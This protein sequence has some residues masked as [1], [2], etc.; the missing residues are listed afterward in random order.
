MATKSTQIALTAK[1]TD[2]QIIGNA[3]ANLITGNNDGIVINGDFGNDTINAGSGDDAIEGNEGNDIIN[4][5]AGFDSISGNTG[6]DTLNGGDNADSLNGNDGNDLING[7]AGEDVLEGGAG[8]DTL[9]GG[10][11]DDEIFGDSGKDIMTGGDGADCF[12]F[13]AADSLVRKPDIITD[14]NKSQGDAL[15][16]G[17][18]VTIAGQFNSAD[19]KAKQPAAAINQAIFDTAK[20]TLYINSDA[21]AAFEF[22][23]ILTG[24]TDFSQIALI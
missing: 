20:N 21:D 24:I 18:L 10:S 4:G 5:G 17:D 13:F 3:L 7:D 2:T 8:N 15:N 9:I 16:F 12:V 6:N 11:V 22:A 1:E 14:F 19:V 23:V